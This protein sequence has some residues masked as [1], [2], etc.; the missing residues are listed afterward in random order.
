MINN[1]IM[2]IICIAKGTFCP[3]FF[4]TCGPPM[5]MSL[6][7]QDNMLVF[8][9]SQHIILKTNIFCMVFILYGTITCWFLSI[10]R[11]PMCC[12]T[13]CCFNPTIRWFNSDGINGIQRTSSRCSSSY[14]DISVERS[15]WWN[16]H[17]SAGRQ[18]TRQRNAHHKH[19]INIMKHKTNFFFP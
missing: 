15:R 1:G 12:Q 16:N 18:K 19:L 5:N 9:V 11:Y 8:E 7:F 13:N 2:I 17:W 4:G 14:L 6:C 10:H 3:R